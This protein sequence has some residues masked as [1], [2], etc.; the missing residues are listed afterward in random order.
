MAAT[1]ESFVFIPTAATSTGKT[2]S[3][4]VKDSPQYLKT[5]LPATTESQVGGDLIT[6]KEGS[7]SYRIVDLKCQVSPPNSV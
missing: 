6:D 3:S 2:N 4:Q 7:S 1:A 5:V